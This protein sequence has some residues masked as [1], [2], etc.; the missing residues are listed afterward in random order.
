MEQGP[1]LYTRPH[2]F[3]NQHFHSPGRLVL[4]Y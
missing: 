2:R 1:E 4:I 3:G